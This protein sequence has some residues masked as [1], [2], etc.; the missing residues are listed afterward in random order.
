MTVP[1]YAPRRKQSSTWRARKGGV[2][3]VDPQSLSWPSD[4]RD[5]GS[6]RPDLRSRLAD[7]HAVGDLDVARYDIVFL[8][9][10]WGAAFDL[11]TS[12]AVADR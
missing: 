10:G 5:T 11:G 12:D 3:P 4:R 1:Y 9:G 7:S 2:I 6:R 8:A